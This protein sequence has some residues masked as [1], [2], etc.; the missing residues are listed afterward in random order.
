M[1]GDRAEPR[2]EGGYA[3]D[4]RSGL[5]I[6]YARDGAHYVGEVDAQG[7]SGVG[8]HYSASGWR[9]EGQFANNRPNGFGVL[10]NERGRVQ[11]AGIFRDARLISRLS[12]DDPSPR[13]AFTDRE[14]GPALESGRTTCTEEGGAAQRF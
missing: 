14:A 4:R 7:M 8:V 6:D 12:R 5:G 1:P 9:Y 3:S 2:F 10:W 11:R 13:A